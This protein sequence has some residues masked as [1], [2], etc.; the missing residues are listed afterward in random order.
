M[1]YYKDISFYNEYFKN[2]EG[3]SLTHE[4]EEK[5][6][7]KNF[8]YIGEFSVDNCVHPLSIRVKVP[9]TFPHRQLR[10]YTKSL[11]GYPHLIYNKEDKESW[12]CLN[13][14]FAE[15]SEQQLNI[16]VSRLKDW[17]RTNLRE[18]RPATI[19]DPKVIAALRQLQAYSWENFDEISE[20]KTDAAVT[21]VGNFAE[22]ADFFKDT[23]GAFDCVIN[24]SNRIFVLPDCKNT[25]KKVPYLIVDENPDD[26]RDFISLRKQYKWDK[27]TCEHLLPEF[28][29]ETENFV[30]SGTSWSKDYV[31]LQSLPENEV[32]DIIDNTTKDAI[33]PDE[34]K[35]IVEEQIQTLKDKVKQ[36]HGY[37]N[38]HE[39]GLNRLPEESDEEFEERQII[40]QQEEDYYIEVYPYE[41]SNFF[42]GI[43]FEKQIT[44]LLFHTNRA[45]AKKKEVTVSLGMEIMQLE[46]VVARP[47]LLDI[48]IAITPEMYFGR[49]SFST[50]ITDKRIA[51]VGVGAIGSMLSESLVRS[52]VK[53]LGLWDNDVVECGNICRSSYTLKDLGDSK[54]NALSRHLHTISPE[55]VV[56]V[57]GGW[58]YVGPNFPTTYMGGDLYG[59]INYNSQE[60]IL[61]EL[62]EYDIV[63]DCTGSNELLHFLGKSLTG[64]ILLSLCI[65]NHANDLLLVSSS[66]GNAFDLR[67]I[68]LSKI[69]QDTMNFFHEGSGCYSPTFLARN[70]DI[71]TLVNIAIRDIAK[72]IEKEQPII[73]TTWSYTNRGIVADRLVSY[74]L[75]DSDIKL[76]ISSEVLLD[77]EDI[78]DVSDG[79]IGYLLG[80]YSSDGKHIMVTHIVDAANAYKKLE[81]AFKTSSGIID[82][83]GDFQLSY[84]EEGHCDSSVMNLIEAKACDGDINTNNPLLAV[85]TPLGVFKCFLFIDGKFKEF[86]PVTF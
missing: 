12:F 9:V 59:N 22:R 72:A 56:K 71:A 8:F 48:P 42:F 79:A 44:W 53:N 21:F 61:K 57:H 64:K 76:S 27:E 38:V 5:K 60:N 73:S 54:V 7:E 17:I 43:R 46:K 45:V 33:Y 49:G 83:I 25:N 78:Y 84:D 67:K 58:K 37:E 77:T 13:S 34:Y 62:E 14:P 11:Y 74:M 31:L 20:Y 52:G 4:F 19:K 86:Y 80:G 41:L 3:F 66:D 28:N 29:A 81:D 82:Y 16:E 1:S 6:I 47:L 51:V 24:R 39:W 65:T 69:E 63:I 70:C 40:N 18:D 36:K 85:R 68:Y 15:T 10:F 35:S 30:H 32:L 26:I 50:A 55:M 2:V 23:K 75:E